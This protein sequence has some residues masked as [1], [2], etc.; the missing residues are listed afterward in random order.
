MNQKYEHS[1]QMARR[2]GAVKKLMNIECAYF[3]MAD[4]YMKYCCRN[5]VVKYSL[6][7]L[8]EFTRMLEL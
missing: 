8:L 2:G 1:G 5:I 7:F 3:L 4:F 6:L